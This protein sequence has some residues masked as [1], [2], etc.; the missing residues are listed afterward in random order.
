MKNISKKEKDLDEIFFHIQE[1]KEKQNNLEISETDENQVNIDF[2]N[3][4]FSNISKEDIFEI[5]SPVYEK[6]D[7][8]N[9]NNLDEIDNIG[10]V[11][12]CDICGCGMIFEKNLSGLVL[13][14]K[15]FACEKC[16]KKSTKNELN[17]WTSSKNAKQSDIKP[18][19]LWLMEK[20]N[21]TR[22][23]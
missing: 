22:L 19:A 7:I 1:I 5:V 10:S 16:C 13:H 12:L 3:F 2:K 18:I 14:G 21:R 11:G 6:N 15:F 23:I 8:S 17:I 9:I 4:D 20:E